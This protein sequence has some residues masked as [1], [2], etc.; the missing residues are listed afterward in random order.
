MSTPQ[1]I[2]D[3]SDSSDPLVSLKDLEVHFEDS[4]LIERVFRDERIVKAV[5]GVSLDI[6]END[7]IALVG[8]SG[9]GKTTLGKAAVGL[10]RPTGGSVEYRGQDIWE[11]KDSRNP[12]ISHDE[13]RRSL[14]IVHQDPASALNPRRTVMSSLSSP[15][16]RWRSNLGTDEREETVHRVLNRVGVTPAEDYA[17][18]YPYQ[19][20]G[21]EQQRVALARTLLMSPDLVLADEAVSALDVSLRVEMMDLMLELQDLF[22]T[23]Y[24]FISH[25]FANAR[26][27][28]EK[29][30][31]R[32]GVMYLGK[33]VEIGPV[34]EVLY[35]PK[36]PYTK[37]L[38]WATP[39]LDPDVAEQTA[40]NQPPVEQIDIPDPVDTP[41]GCN[42]HPRCPQARE[43]CTENQP[44]IITAEDGT[45]AACFRQDDDHEYWSSPELHE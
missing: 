41:S 26:Y 44:D 16:K 39:V 23:S 32:I 5:D 33:L 42:F 40:R 38:I 29:A 34:E 19:L 31:G 22:E 4:G 24:L 25:D 45:K 43:A 10:Q 9:C 2:T 30:D 11:A 36:H 1:I 20:S 13:I 18:R 17:M 35:N 15:L 27:L 3:E 14:Q 12:D 7:V 28:A 21:G 6:E 8:E 37:V